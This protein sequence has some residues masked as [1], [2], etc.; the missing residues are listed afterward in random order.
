MNT[1]RYIGAVGWGW[2][3]ECDSW[4]DT[5]DDDDGNDDNIGAA[6]WGWVTEYDC[7]CD[8]DDDKYTEVVDVIIV[9]DDEMMIK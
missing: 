2:V 8:T 9:V 7:S 6:G 5:D 1:L 3:F 4:C